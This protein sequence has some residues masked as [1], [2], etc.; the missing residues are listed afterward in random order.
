MTRTILIS[1]NS[2]MSDVSKTKVVAVTVTYNVDHRFEIA[3]K[4][5][6]DQVDLVVI[7]DNSNSSDAQ[8]LLRQIVEAD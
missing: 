8:A 6:L 1:D 5:Y 4:S 7:V 2:P 3:L